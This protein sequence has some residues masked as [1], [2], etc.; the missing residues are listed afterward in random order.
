MQWITFFSKSV[1]VIKNIH[2]QRLQRQKAL[3]IHLH[4]KTQQMMKEKK[5]LETGIVVFLLK[6]IHFHFAQ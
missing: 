2:S 3:S 5:L 1:F 6:F 4:I